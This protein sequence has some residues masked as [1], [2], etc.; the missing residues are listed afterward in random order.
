VLAPVVALV[1]ALAA[2]WWHPEF[3]TQDG[4]AHLYNAHI[5]AR[6]FDPASPF[7][8][9][10]EVHWEPLPNWAGHLALTGLVA[11]LPPR[12]ADRAMTTA[13]LVAFAAAVGWLRGRV[14][15]PRGWLEASAL[16]ALLALNV[17]WLLGFTSFLL[18][19]CLFPVALGVWWSGRVEGWSARRASAL[20]GLTV[21]GYFCHIVSLGL[22]AV[23]LAV[24]EALTPAPPRTRRGRA[25]TTAAGL[26]PLLPLGLVYLRLMRG[27]GGGL[28]PEWKH[29]AHPLSP[30]AWAD[31]LTWVDPISLARKDYLPLI[32]TSAP[33]HLALAPVLWLGAAL[34]VGIVIRVAGAKRSGPRGSQPS[35][36]GHAPLCPGHPN[37]DQIRAIPNLDRGWWALAAL[38]LIAGAAG[39]DTLGANHGEYLQQRVVLLGLVALVPVVRFDPGGRVGRAGALVLLAGALALQSAAVWDYARTADRTAGALMRAAP[40]V[41]HR[42]RVATRLTGIRFPFRANPLLHADAA[43]GVG[44]GNVLW[45]DYEARLYYFPVRFRAGLDRPDPADLERVALADDPRDAPDRAR[46]WAR[47]LGRHQNAIDTLV[48]WG[49]DPPLDAVSARWFRPAGG[50]GPVRVWRR[51]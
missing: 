37:E 26:A 49:D 16:P 51:K 38:L 29:L 7:R 20:A 45:S 35:T 21:L 33:W 15:G 10:F 9:A 27:G 1:P 47:L 17:A 12:A 40:A 28:A 44:T 25:L 30:R 2:V 50:E 42:Q 11:A 6:S 19:A 18:G 36:P 13:T 4:P 46:L 48:T 22:T 23:G 31:Q 41:G 14:A 32:G 24:L 8:D 5:L 3:V 34:A 43:L 39:P